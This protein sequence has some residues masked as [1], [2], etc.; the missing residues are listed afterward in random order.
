MKTLK[1][2]ILIIG[3]ILIVGLFALKIEWVKS[4]ILWIDSIQD[5]VH[6]DKVI[7]CMM[8]IALIFT[9]VHVARHWS[10]QK[11]SKK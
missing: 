6:P 4:T 2:L 9:I 7:L 5:S 1:H 10:D 3:L 8:A 11:E